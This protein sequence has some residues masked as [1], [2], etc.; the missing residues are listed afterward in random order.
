[1]DRLGMTLFASIFMTALACEGG[2]EIP[3]PAK[4]EPPG[5]TQA[6]SSDPRTY[7]DAAGFK[8]RADLIVQGV[9]SNFLGSYRKGWFGKGGDPG[10]Y[11]I[12]IAMARLLLDPDE[13]ESRQY[14]NDHRTFAE[15]YHF[16]AVNWARFYPLFS[17]ALTADTLRK[18]DAEAAKYTPYLESVGTENHKVMWLSSANVLPYYVSGDTFARRSIVAAKE[19]AKAKLRKYVKDLYAFGQGE[20]DSSTYMPYDVDGMLNVYDFSKDEECRLL[21]RAALDWYAAAHALKYSD[22]VF[23]SP[24]QRGFPSGAVATG[25]DQIGW[26]WWGCEASIDKEHVRRALV[27]MHAVTSGWRPNRVLCH[28]ARRDIAVLPFEQRNSKPNYYYGQGI[29]AVG[30]VYHESVYVTRHYTMGGLWNGHGSQITRF[31][32]AARTTNGGVVFTGGNPRK[33]DHTG[34]I[35]GIGY[36]DGN[37]RYDQSA[38]IG[39]AWMN[40]SR[41]PTNET[42]AVFSFFSY[43]ASSRPAQRGDWWVMRAGATFVAVRPVGEKV[44]FAE[45]TVG[46]GATQEVLRVDGRVT[47]LVV[48]TA[49]TDRYPDESDLVTALK[50]KTALDTAGLQGDGR[51]TYKTLSGRSVTM[52]FQEGKDRALTTIDGKAVEFGNWPVYGG[53][54]V[55]QAQG[56][57]S[58]TDGKAGYSIDFTGDLPVYSELAP[59]AATEGAGSGG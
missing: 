59:A 43:P 13:A 4:V 17:G 6:P 7:P 50:E 38:Q 20:W 12:P 2:W 56:V 53:P 29:P 16:A 19:Q 40:I 47:A 25:A 51:M 39:P 1:M 3:D 14:M 18:F 9:A 42:E 15:H 33:S 31:Q 54:C 45:V 22:G 48:E 27:A 57:L 26:L 24:N 41:A 8:L 44:G 32:V 55:K 46:K 23:T 36:T 5:V 58:V 10:K 52:Q 28:I 30:S 37:G 34:A 21:A 11:T 35:A 49:D